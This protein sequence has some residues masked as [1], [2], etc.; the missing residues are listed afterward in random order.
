MA[1]LE[2][3]DWLLSFMD[4]IQTALT[5]DVRPHCKKHFCIM[6]S[7]MNNIQE[8]CMVLVFNDKLIN[9][10]M[11]EVI[12]HLDIVGWRITWVWSNAVTEPEELI[13]I[14]FSDHQ[15]CLKPSWWPC[16]SFLICLSFCLLENCS[17]FLPLKCE[18]WLRWKRQGW[19]LF[20]AR[21]G[22]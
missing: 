11:I 8:I 10:R 7:P 21:K 6:V 4:G 2:L 20:N 5:I 22:A 1:I 12:F 9:K 13:T 14:F 19:D 15:Q 18:Q 3:L 16:L 17:F